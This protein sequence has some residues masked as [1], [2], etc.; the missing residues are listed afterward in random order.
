MRSAC[1]LLL[2]LAAVGASV[3]PTV[4]LSQTPPQTPPSGEAGVPLVFPFEDD[5]IAGTQAG[6]LTRDDAG[7]VYA[8]TPRGLLSFDGVR[9]RRHWVRSGTRSVARDAQ[10]RLW[11][12]TDGELG[13]F[14]ADSLGALAYVSRRDSLPED[15]RARLGNQLIHIR[16]TV[17]VT[18]LGPVLVR[19]D[20]D[21]QF[22]SWPVEDGAHTALVGDTFYLVEPTRGLSEVRADGPVSIASAPLPGPNAYIVS[23]PTSNAARPLLMVTEQQLWRI[24]RASMEPFGTDAADYLREAAIRARGTRWLPSGLLAVATKRGGLVLLDAEGRLRQI[25]DDDAGL[26]SPSVFAVWED[27]ERGLWIGTDEG[28]AYRPPHPITQFDE[29]AG[30][31]GIVLDVERHAGRLHAATSTGIYRMVQAATPDRR[32]RFEALEGVSGACLDLLSSQGRLFAA[33]VDG[34]YI[35]APAASRVRLLDK[36]STYS[37]TT[38]GTHTWSLDA[39][40]ILSSLRFDGAEWTATPLDTVAAGS[41]TMMQAMPDGTLWVGTR[42]GT[43]HRVEIDDAGRPAHVDAWGRDDGLVETDWAMPFEVDGRPAIGTKTGLYRYRPDALPAFAI[44]ESLGRLLLDEARSF[45]NVF[46]LDTDANGDVWYYG[47]D[48]LAV[49]RRTDDG[50][51][52]DRTPIQV[53]YD[54]GSYYTLTTE[55]DGAVW[56]GGTTG[57]F[58]L[59]NGQP[60]TERPYPALVRRVSTVGA[61]SL[62]AA[63]HRVSE[64]ITPLDAATNALRFE[65]A[66]TSPFGPLSFRYR[67][68]PFEETWSDWSE[69]AEK[70]YTNLPPGSY[71][72]EVEAEDARVARSEVGRFSFDIRPP[73]H[74]TIWARLLFG[75]AGLTLLAGIAVLADRRRSRLLSDRA[76]ALEA[77]VEE[78]TAE[79]HRQNDLLMAQ[80]AQLETQ[81]EQ[82]REVDRLKTRFFAN[83]SHEFRTPLTL[84]I[85]PLEDIREGRH[86][87]VPAPVHDY[88]GLALRNARRVLGLINEILDVAK[89]E[90]GRLQLQA[91]EQD[92][93]DFVKTVAEAF[94]PVAERQGLT[95]RV[96]VPAK[97]L[98]VFFEAVH[99]EK[100]LLNLLS[101][102]FKFTPVGGTIRVELRATD[103]EAQVRVRD[104][105]PGISVGDLDRLFDRFYQTSES[106]QRRQPGTGVGLSLAKELTDLHG[107]VITVESEEGFGSTFT[108]T[109]PLG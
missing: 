29:R 58:R 50:Y 6:G 87:P 74:A 79:V 57:L 34:T 108:V 28:L 95:Y 99:L 55:P 107:G 98:P 31:N 23:A 21:A 60:R 30:L 64:V 75:V 7:V 89:L 17:S 46:L 16:G 81:A 61:D 105:G 59:A 12:T 47:G 82:L 65:F 24:E 96:D 37:L 20:D 68:L 72:F 10:G 48:E 36:R 3:F 43:V 84:T 94:D 1:S 92:L 9:W 19:W 39:L 42:M 2:L 67:L 14:T 52:H 18:A 100:V 78:R 63:S 11:I 53:L 88:L 4:L 101:N 45:P 93:R 8:A 25:I 77:A 38:D 73:W 13:Y 71:A 22:Q 109:L 56:L 70:E 44:D 41:P 27:P 97:P 106:A 90:A 33:C 85:G 80:T 32:A 51:R 49:A 40:S 86:G 104:S 66:A 91:S 69:I 54:R 103:T 102:A 5:N 26:P 62:L 83:V 15:A 76:R 35:A